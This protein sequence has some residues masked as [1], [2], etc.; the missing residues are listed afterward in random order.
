MQETGGAGG[1]RETLRD[2]SPWAS[3]MADQ[4]LI[5]VQ[6]E[7]RLDKNSTLCLIALWPCSMADLEDLFVFGLFLGVY[8]YHQ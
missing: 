7:K 8:L 3:R 6:Q 4:I 1:V 2:G 5:A